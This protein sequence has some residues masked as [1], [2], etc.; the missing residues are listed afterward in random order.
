MNIG[1][2]KS[3]C[4][5]VNAETESFVTPLR[6]AIASGSIRCC[7]L[8]AA[9]GGVESIKRVKGGYRTILDMDEVLKYDWPDLNHKEIAR[10]KF[11]FLLGKGGGADGNEARGEGI[12]RRE[13]EGGEGAEAEAEETAVPYRKGLAPPADCSF[14]R[15]LDRVID[16]KARNLGRK[17]TYYML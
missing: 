1:A 2:E 8:L 13:G 15:P 4:V 3:S 6:V 11:K 12:G 16:S 14:T 17:S 7:K 10:R 5:N 9:S